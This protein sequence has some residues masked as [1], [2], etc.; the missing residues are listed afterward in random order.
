MSISRTKTSLLQEVNGKKYV[1]YPLSYADIIFLVNDD[2][3]A[4]NVN[5]QQKIKEID[6]LVAN[7]SNEILDLEKSI[8]EKDHFK[9]WH[10]SFKELVEAHKVSDLKAGDYAIIGYPGKDDELL[11]FDSTEKSWIV[12]GKFSSGSIST[13]NGKI[14]NENGAVVIYID[15]IE[16]LRE[17][18]NSFAKDSELKE[19]E[20]K[21]MKYNKEWQSNITYKKND[22]V[23]YENKIYVSVDED[24]SLNVKPDLIG[25]T[26][27]D[28]IGILKTATK[29]SE[30]TNDSDFTT[31]AY[32][33]ERLDNFSGGGTSDGS[34]KE[35]NEDENAHPYIL[36]L[37]P[38]VTKL[39]G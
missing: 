29:T 13:V 19:L 9:G 36:N 21:T 20:N 18:L 6:E 23:V 10:T 25:N 14:P 32:V 17:E 15:D 8:K 12:K 5:I 11:I 27:W 30:L 2:G 3:S 4:S 26:S 7:N 16:N 28:M 34:I 37:L 38:T 22:V 24:G 1:V 35:H 33:D 39:E 31:K